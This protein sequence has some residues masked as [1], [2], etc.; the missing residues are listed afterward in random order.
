MTVVAAIRR[1]LI[2]R[3]RNILCL[4]LKVDIFKEGY[5]GRWRLVAYD[6]LLNKLMP[7]FVPQR[8]D[9]P[10]VP[11]DTLDSVVRLSAQGRVGVDGG[12]FEQGVEFGVRV[13]EPVV[14]PV[15]S[16]GAFRGSFP[17]RGSRGTTCRSIWPL[18]RLTAR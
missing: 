4:S 3:L 2:V 13:A 16:G 8:H 17:R 15:P 9:H 14:Q 18:D 5:A 11:R 7:P 6:V 12:L 10:V 1:P